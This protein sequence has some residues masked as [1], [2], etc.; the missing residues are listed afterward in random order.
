MIKR[1]LTPFL[2]AMFMVGVA[3]CGEKKEAVPVANYV[4]EDGSTLSVRFEPEA[5]I[6][7]LE[8]GTELNLPQQRAA[9]GMWYSS[10]THELRGKGDEATWGIGRRVPVQCKAVE[11]TAAQEIVIEEQEQVTA[12]GAAAEEPQAANTEIDLSDLKGNVWLAEDINN[13]GIIDRARV[14]MEFSDNGLLSGR[15]GCNNYSGG[16]KLTGNKLEVGQNMVS[17]MMACAESLM[18]LERKYLDILMAADTLHYNEHG[19][20][21]LTAKDGSTIRFFKE[22]PPAKMAE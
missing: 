19:A 15:S 12:E 17:T 10:G 4:C 2:C 1:T 7:T 5:A 21:I 16:Y 6:V 22:T 3:A 13:G 9:S 11:T 18:D 8:N 14:S 20:L